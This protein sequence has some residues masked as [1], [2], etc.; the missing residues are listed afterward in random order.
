L[1]K[2]IDAAYITRTVVMKEICEMGGSNRKVFALMNVNIEASV[3]AEID[4]M[5]E[6]N[7][8]TRSQECRLAIR[9]YLERERCRVKD[10]GRAA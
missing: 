9:Q 8:R 4:A 10:E 1:S 2:R 5:A 6:R 3:K 7:C